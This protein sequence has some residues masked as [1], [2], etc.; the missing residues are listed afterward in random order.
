MKTRFFF[1]SLMISL[2][3]SSCTQQKSS[4]IE[5][6]WQFV[7]SKAMAG[8][9]LISQFPRTNYL[10]SDIKMWSKNHFVFVGRFKSDTTFSDNYGGGT[11]KLDG[12]RYEESILYHTNTS[13]V[14]MKV[15]MLLEI[16]NDTLIQ[17]WPADENW[18]LPEKF[19]TEK[20]VRLK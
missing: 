4:P 19:S 13:A 5:G 7:S 9:T 10:G 1:L 18:N 8:D 2:I 16:R 17:K 15:K 3:I 12:N 11:Y 14:G 6:A 20:Y